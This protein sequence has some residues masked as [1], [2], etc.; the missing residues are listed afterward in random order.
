MFA[1]FLQHFHE[2]K[3]HRSSG[4]LFMFYVLLVFCS[5][6]QLRWEIMRF[7]ASSLD[8][9]NY[10]GFQFIYYVTFFTL[11][12][13]MLTLNLFT[14]KPPRYTTYPKYANPSPELSASMVNRA[15]FFFFDPTAWAG[16]RRPLTEKNIYDIN[17]EN[18]S[19]ELVPEFDKNFQRSLER[20][21]RSGSE[22]YLINCH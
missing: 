20:Q 9:L 11:I 17:P 2:R 15:F 18:A 21:K 3:G 12:S 7:Q 13:I 5:I 19:S 16:W 1:L 6:P 14:D 22:C 10:L 8:P 4:L